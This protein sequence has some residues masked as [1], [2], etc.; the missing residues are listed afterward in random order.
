MYDSSDEAFSSG[1]GGEPTV[2][3]GTFMGA[4]WQ[5][6]LDPEHPRI[7]IDGREAHVRA[8]GFGNF[9]T[10]LMVGRWHDLGEL[11]QA[12][13]MYHPSYSP[14]ARRGDMTVA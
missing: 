13:T 7:V 6:L 11:A 12:I 10:H 8:D 14:L 9:V 3:R 2:L 5:A 4:S 1:R